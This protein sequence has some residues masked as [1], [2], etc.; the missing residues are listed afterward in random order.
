MKKLLLAAGVCTALCFVAFFLQGCLKDK[1]SH[2]YTIL[3]P[4]YETKEVVKAN[5]KSN[6]SKTI[7]TPGKIYLYDNYVFLNEPDKGVH[8]IDNS[9]PANP[10]MKAFIDIP[11]N[12]DIAVKGNTLYA[13]MYGSLVSIDI[14]D[15]LNAILLKE[16]PGVF[17]ERNYMGGFV[18]NNSMIIVGWERKDTTVEEVLGPNKDY[19][20]FAQSDSTMNAT[21]SAA[22][23]PVGMGG[24]LARFSIV[25][26]YLY[27]VDR[28]TLHSVSIT[29]AS[30]P[31]LVGNW[32]AGF[33]IETIYPL[34][35]KLFIG[36]MGGMYIYDISNPASPVKKGNFGHARA[37]DPVVADDNYAYVTLKAGTTCG[38][39]ENELQ[40]VDIKDVT[41]PSLLMKYS[42]SGPSGL[43]KDGNTLFVCD[44]K[45][46][47][48]VYN[49]A[50]YSKLVLIKQINNIEPVDVIAWNGNAL[51]MTKDGLYQYDYSNL[52]NIHLSSRLSF[53]N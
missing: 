29:N 8:V 47:L 46:G 37:C 20:V 1:V 22:A 40:I 48:K 30:D 51:V 23:A 21:P 53:S 6:P 43:S 16:I 35:D 36:S 52:N 33:D 12:Q 18:G 38:P 7:G 2:S 17:P 10:V 27:A 41:A 25:N 39:T 34:K 44:G 45:E 32:P 49:A 4:I 3:R 13:D 11:G 24:S 26:D 15:P 28:H 14:T 42:M 5:I 19:V 50:D 31:K 9:N